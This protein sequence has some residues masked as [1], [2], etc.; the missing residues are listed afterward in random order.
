VDRAADIDRYVLNDPRRAC[1]DV[2]LLRRLNRPRVP[3]HAADRPDADWHRSDHEPAAAATWRATLLCYGS[4][5]FD[6]YQRR[7]WDGDNRDQ[8]RGNRQSD[9][10][11]GSDSS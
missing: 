10:F 5:R 4:L 6:E 7:C 11:I 3:E 9:G 1:H 2:D 8:H